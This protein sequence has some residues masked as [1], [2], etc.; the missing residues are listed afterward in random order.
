MRQRAS[1]CAAQQRGCCAAH[2]AMPDPGPALLTMRRSFRGGVHPTLRN[3]T[4]PIFYCRRP[5]CSPTLEPTGARCQPI[6]MPKRPF[7]APPMFPRL[8]CC[9]PVSE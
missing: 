9:A 7:P 8:P 2:V 3:H 6:L 5:L 1:L 4:L